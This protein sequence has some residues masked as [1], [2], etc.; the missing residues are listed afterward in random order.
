MST[1][2]TPTNLTDYLYYSWTATDKTEEYLIYIYFA[3]IERLKRNETRE[4]NVYLNGDYWG[5]PISPTD[6]TTSTYF[7]DCFN[8]SSYELTLV[9]TQNSTLPPLYNAIELYNPRSLQQ[10]QTND[11]DGR[12][13]QYTSSYYF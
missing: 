6:H 8:S 4:F 5:G 1:A 11:Q 13:L 2:I 12:A 3:E 9:R 7:T 10:L